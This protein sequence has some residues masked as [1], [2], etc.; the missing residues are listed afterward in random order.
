MVTTKLLLIFALL[1]TSAL[2]V[3]AEY[4][5]TGRK[6]ISAISAA[7]PHLDFIWT[8]AEGDLD[9]DGIAD[10]ALVA[11]GRRGGNPQREERL[12][13]LKG[14]PDGSYGVLSVSDEFCRVSKFYNIDIKKNSVFVQA[15]EYADAA[16]ASSYTMQ[17]RY[18]ASL[19]DLEF[20]GEETLDE[21]YNDGSYYR[22]S[23]NYLTKTAIHSRH[24]GKRHKDVNVRLNSFPI[25]RLQG[26]DCSNRGSSDSTVHIDENFKV[27]SR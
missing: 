15:V 21:N 12:F 20:V 5:P 8:S 22:V 6:A 2:P 25:L 27:R 19:K 7:F 10:L 3:S 23:N 14:N 26:F 1:C 24:A 16:R 4:T 17:F 13:I 9:G 11:T 18:N